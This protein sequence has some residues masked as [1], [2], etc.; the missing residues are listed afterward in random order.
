M[1]ALKKLAGQTAIY[2]L[3][4][5]LGRFLNYLLVPLYTN[6]DYFKT[7]EY[8]VITDVYAVS[9]FLAILLIYGME[10]SFFRFSEKA[11]NPQKVLGTSLTS[12]LLTTLL[13]IASLFLFTDTYADWLKYP[14]NPEY[15]I[16]VGLFLAFD[17][18]SAI[19]MAKLRRDKRPI[20]FALINFTNILTYI[21][22]NLIFILF[23]LNVIK[24]GGSNWITENII[25]PEVGLGYV[26]IA[27]LFASGIKLL[28]LLPIYKNVSFKLDKQLLKQMFIYSSPL[29][30][31]GFA[32]IINETL[33]R[34]LLRVLLEPELGFEGALSKTGIYGAC[35]KLS[36]IISLTT[37]AFRYA[38]EP[39]FFEREK[40][41]GAKQMYAKVMDWFTIFLSIVFLFVML[42]IDVFKY[43]IRK[44]EYWE[45]LG[46]VPILMLANIFL[47]WIFN[48]SIWYKLSGKTKYG[49][50]ISICGALVTLTMNFLLIPVM[51][52]H[53][54]AWATFSAYGTMAVISYFLGQKHYPIPY[55][56]LKI[57]GFTGLS[58]ILWWASTFIGEPESALKYIV[59]TG[60]FILY[61]SIVFLIEKKQ[62]KQLLK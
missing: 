49:A 59:N 10:T 58:V 5:I 41:K 19:P 18:L 40:E 23:G 37:Q 60:I 38:A 2:G 48:L 33:D 4:S 17:A 11:E 1:S 56:L 62:I 34:R 52:Y 43:F 3:P 21:G 15:V 36:I 55:N 14:N 16:W 44:K 6:T 42:Y 9:A 29:I 31:A 30:I 50:I 61:L 8:G 46:V 25:D 13:F 12:I 54:A 27:N 26:F 35:Y 39:F 28:L 51:G 57:L 47:G 32:G 45:G 7:S 22:F 53:G 24:D 20:R